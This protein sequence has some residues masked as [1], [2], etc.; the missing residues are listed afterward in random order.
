MGDDHQG[1]NGIEFVLESTLKGVDG[2]IMN[3]VDVLGRQI[4]FSKEKYIDAIDGYDVYL[5]IDE[6]VQYLAEKAM[7][8]AMLDYNL[9]RGA[10]C[11]V[12]DPHTGEILAMV[13]KPD[14]NP[15]DPDALP[16]G[17]IDEDW[18]GFNDSEDSQILWQTVFRNR[19]VMDTYEPGSVFKAITAAAAIEENVVETST[20]KFCRPVSIAGHTINCWR[21]GGHGAEDFLHAVYNS[22]NPVFVDVAMDLGIEK[23][24]N[25]F[26]LFGFKE[27]PELSFRES[28][29]MRSLQSFS[30]MIQ[31][32]LTW[33]LLPSDNAFKYLRFR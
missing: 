31:R 32:K 17:I 29:P 24:Y 23:F 25:Y 18:K 3:E 2:K 8:Q 30:I 4:S 11:V 15:N 5:T 22:C 16:V 10:T 26:K 14:F 27:K 33:R 19:A 7:D 20:P 12:M 28:R 21:K 13:S 6:T 1:L 9:K